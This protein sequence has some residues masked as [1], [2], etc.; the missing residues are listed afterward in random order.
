MYALCRSNG[1][2]TALS[3]DSVRPSLRPPVVV[4]WYSGTIGSEEDKIHAR[5]H[6]P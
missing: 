5:D 6:P 2:L 4:L 1:P 3:A